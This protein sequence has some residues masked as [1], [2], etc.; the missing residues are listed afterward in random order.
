MSLIRVLIVDDSPM[1]RQIL[2]GMLGAEADI[3][4]VGYARDGVEALEQTIQ[5]RPDVITMDLEMPRMSGLLA[6][7]QIGLQ[8]PCPVIMCANLSEDDEESPFQA[9]AGG[10]VGFVPKP[11]DGNLLVIPHLKDRLLEKIR[12]AAR[13]PVAI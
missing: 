13:Y 4:V 7:R 2:S 1:I 11:I 10:A 8:C 9:M 5:L 12:S 3:E 6:L